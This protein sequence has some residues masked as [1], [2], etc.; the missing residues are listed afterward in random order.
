MND[1]E[2]T[3]TADQVDGFRRD[4]S[5]AVSRH[6]TTLL[7]TGMDPK[8]AVKLTRD[9]QAMVL[10]VNDPAEVHVFMDGGE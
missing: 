1:L 6:Y 5:R 4:V 9:F 8:H 2:W 3:A 10:E 7:E